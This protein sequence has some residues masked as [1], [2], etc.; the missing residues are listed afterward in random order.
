LVVEKEVVLKKA[1]IN[2]MQNQNLIEDKE[3]SMAIV[4]QH[5][6]KDNNS[7]FYIGIGKNIKRAYSNRNR[8]KHWVNIV[9]KY[10]YDIDI[11][12]EGIEYEDA[13]NVEFGLINAYGRLDIGTGILVNL[14]DG[15][16]GSI[17][18]KHKEE[19]INKISGVNSHKYG[20]GYLQAGE[21]NHMFGKFGIKNPSY[22]LTGYK[23]ARSKE[24][25][26]YDIKTKELINKFGS[27]RE[28]YR[29]TG[30]HYVSISQCCNNHPNYTHA[31]GYIWKYN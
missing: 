29:L 20:K 5:R 4:Y 3:G 25:F 6:R 19:T 12:F 27:T 30:V 14:T 11:L 22:G 8:N 31:G 24:V 18:F 10:G 1:T 13:C 9:S 23:S 28:A 7:I 17:N 26:Q 16:K 2:I 21:K 15:G